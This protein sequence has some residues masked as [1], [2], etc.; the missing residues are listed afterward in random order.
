MNGRSGGSLQQHLLCTCRNLSVIMKVLDKVI[1][2]LA[3]TTHW[4]AL[5]LS[6]LRG[7]DLYHWIS[8]MS[9]VF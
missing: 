1:A 4:L 8:I 9:I 3:T 2:A 6:H 5:N 7:G